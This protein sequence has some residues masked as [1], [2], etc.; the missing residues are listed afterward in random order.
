LASKTDLDHNIIVVSSQEA[1]SPRN[2][3]HDPKSSADERPREGLEETPMSEGWESFNAPGP[4]PTVDTAV[5]AA[6]IFEDE[7][8]TKRTVQFDTLS[9]NHCYWKRF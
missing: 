3:L 4:V 7:K 6:R 2:L 9:L 1:F 5:A 8:I